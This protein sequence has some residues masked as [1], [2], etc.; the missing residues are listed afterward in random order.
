MNNPC[1][2]C[3]SQALPQCTCPLSP[4]AFH[5]PLRTLCQTSNSCV[6]SGAGVQV[7]QEPFLITSGFAAFFV[8]TAC[9]AVAISLSRHC[10]TIVDVGMKCS[11]LL[12]SSVAPD[13]SI[14]TS[15][16]SKQ[17][18]LF[19]LSP[20]Y[21][22]CLSFCVFYLSVCFPHAGEDLY[23]CECLALP[24]TGSSQTRERSLIVPCSVLF[25]DTPVCS[26]LWCSSTAGASSTAIFS[27]G[28]L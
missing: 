5:V 26:T 28:S 20:C 23:F 4:A 21:F 19:S 8:L 2:S 1:P 11:F 27:S 3:S 12:I 10:V 22:C 18:L 14:G 9:C 15:L 6:K 24:Q 17:T 13:V 25:S 7:F 16:V